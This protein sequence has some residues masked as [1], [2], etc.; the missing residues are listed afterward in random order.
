MK[1]LVIILLVIAGVFF[2]DYFIISMVG[3]IANFCEANCGFYETTFR[4]ISWAVVISSMLLVILVYT[5]K[6]VAI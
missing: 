3:I 2:I 6:R 1:N 4:F 5:K